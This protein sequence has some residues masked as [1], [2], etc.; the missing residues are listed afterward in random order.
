MTSILEFTM[1][2]RSDDEQWTSEMFV[3]VTKSYKINKLN[4]SENQRKKE[5]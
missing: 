1:K 3:S 4:N 5:V 2:Y